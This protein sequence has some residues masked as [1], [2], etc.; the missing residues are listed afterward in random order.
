MDAV[1]LMGCETTAPPRT[2]V[3]ETLMVGGG[4]E[5]EPQPADTR[6]EQRAKR[7]AE[8]ER[9]RRRIPRV[10]FKK[11]LPFKLSCCGTAGHIRQRLGEKA[12]LVLDE[13]YHGKVS[14]GRLR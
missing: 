7:T 6:Q 13:K 4:L 10:R 8:I 3:M 9:K 2:G 12:A 11:N 14:A 1:N 5:C